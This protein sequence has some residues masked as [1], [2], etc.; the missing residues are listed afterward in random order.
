MNNDVKT[1]VKLDRMRYKNDSVPEM[2]AILAIVFNVLYFFSI[3]ETNADF[4]YTYFIGMSIIV[5]LLFL[6]VC[7]LSS[8]E[9]KNYHSTYAYVMI[10]LAVLQVI[11]IFYYPM[12]AL[13]AEAITSGQSTLCIAYLVASAAC[14]VV[15]GIIS[16]NNSGKLNKYLE[17]IGK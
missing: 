4:F 16:I 12:K 2:L 11:R 13:E 15:G 9:V 17:T 10:G 1:D 5:N 7:F 14:L 8:E 6:L 3:Y